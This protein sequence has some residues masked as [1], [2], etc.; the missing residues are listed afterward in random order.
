MQPSQLLLLHLVGFSAP[1]LATTYIHTKILLVNQGKHA[2]HILGQ[3]R[4]FFLSRNEAGS[5]IK[6]EK[7]DDTGQSCPFSHDKLTLHLDPVVLPQ[8]SGHRIVPF[9]GRPPTCP[10]RYLHSI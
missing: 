8:Q 9:L 10:L 4:H 7:K 3:C 2:L 5:K 1:D 6:R